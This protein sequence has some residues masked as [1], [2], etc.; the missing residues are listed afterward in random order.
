MACSSSTFQTRSYLEFKR[1]GQRALIVIVHWWV[2]ATGEHRPA[3]KLR[4]ERRRTE[5]E[6]QAWRDQC[7]H[8]FDKPR[9]RQDA[10]FRGGR[11]NVL[12]A[13]LLSRGGQKRTSTRPQLSVKKKKVPFWSERAT[14]SRIQAKAPCTSST[15][16]QKGHKK[17]EIVEKLLN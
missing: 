16:A 6:E 2:R 9:K 5:N 11:G 15:S 17:E 7:E 4:C 12:R 14:V 13:V 10:G 3:S 8:W 1:C